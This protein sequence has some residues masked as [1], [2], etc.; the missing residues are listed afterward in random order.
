MNRNVF[1]LFATTAIVTIACGSSPADPSESS[2]VDGVVSSAVEL[3]SAAPPS[4]PIAVLGGLDLDG[5]C[6]SI[7]FT[8]VTLTK[9]DS[10]HNAAFNNWRCTTADGGTQPFSME[11]AC[12]SQYSATAV[13]AHPTDPDNAFSWLCYG[14]PAG[15]DPITLL[16]GLDLDGYCLSIGFAGVTLTRPDSGPNAAFNNWRCKTAD[17][18]THPFSMEQACKWQY[19]ANAVQAHP[20]DPDNAFSW[21]CYATPAGT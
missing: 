2:P 5:Y 4:D 18:A 13:Q 1:A 19:S 17:G 21:L 3:A 14:K 12:K 20:T 6:L 9:P 8:G 7:G 15:T 10:G 11:Q 16:G